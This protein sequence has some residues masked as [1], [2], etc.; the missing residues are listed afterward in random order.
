MSGDEGEKAGLAAA[1]AV[2]MAEQDEL[3]DQAERETMSDLF[4]EIVP[5][6]GPGRPAGAQN[7]QTQLEVA[8]IKA[9]GQSPLAFLSSIWRDPLKPLD[10]RIQSAIAALPYMHRKLPLDVTI[11]QEPMTLILGDGLADDAQAAEPSCDVLEAD[12]EEVDGDEL[13]ASENTMKT[14]G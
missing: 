1:V 4:G 8:A 9:S 6:R 5:A 7:R 2:C 12:F 14:E 10:R 13:D 11:N 3:R